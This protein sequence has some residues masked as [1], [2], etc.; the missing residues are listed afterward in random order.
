MVGGG[1]SYL[2]KW[3]RFP[4]ALV[5][6]A[7][8]EPAGDQQHPLDVEVRQGRMRLR[9]GRVLQVLGVLGVIWEL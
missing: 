1:G 9:D 7:L 4:G 5:V 3:V 8:L 2:H 6:H